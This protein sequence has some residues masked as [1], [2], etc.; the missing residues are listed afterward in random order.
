MAVVV[1]VVVVVVAAAAAVD[2]VSEFHPID[3][4]ADMGEEALLDMSDL[5]ILAQ[6]P[7]CE[8]PS[9]QRPLSRA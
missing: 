8:L 6:L 1:V 2:D 4:I 5:A 3:E 7:L 9:R